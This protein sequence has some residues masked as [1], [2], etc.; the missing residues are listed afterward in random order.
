MGVDGNYFVAIH[1]LYNLKFPV[2]HKKVNRLYTLLSMH[3]ATNGNN[4]Q[5][6]PPSEEHA[7]G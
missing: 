3:N 5:F 4:D 6:K 1:F 7:G 2:Q